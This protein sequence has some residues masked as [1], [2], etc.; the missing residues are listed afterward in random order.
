MSE[1][2]SEPSAEFKALL[3]VLED[4]TS[5]MGGLQATEQ[6]Q[7]RP[8]LNARVPRTSK[9]EEEHLFNLL[10]ILHVLK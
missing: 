3:L 9:N 7:T 1:T 4:H 2:V 10:G 5:V 6:S 8:F